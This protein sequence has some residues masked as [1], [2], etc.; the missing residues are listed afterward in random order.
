MSIME[1][2]MQEQIEGAIISKERDDL[3]DLITTFLLERREHDRDEFM[4]RSAW[5]R[6]EDKDLYQLAEIIECLIKLKFAT[7]DEGDLPVE[8]NLI[9]RKKFQRQH[10][11]KQTYWHRA[12]TVEELFQPLFDAN[13]N[14][15]IAQ[16]ELDRIVSYMR[17]LKHEA[18]D[19]EES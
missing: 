3:D 10:W 16:D 5:P 19:A 14:V 17:L 7:D 1:Q 15:A 9:N 8:F 11:F 2:K 4:L 13:T 18:E 12:D 6:I